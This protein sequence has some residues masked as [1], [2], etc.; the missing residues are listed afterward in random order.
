MGGIFVR[1]DLDVRRILRVRLQERNNRIE[2]AECAFACDHD[3]WNAVFL[4]GK[5]ARN[6]GSGSRR[7][8]TD[9]ER[10]AVR[11]MLAADTVLL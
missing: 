10:I 9:S 8:R 2:Y 1:G 7:K 6:A 4:D 5:R 3:R 11:M